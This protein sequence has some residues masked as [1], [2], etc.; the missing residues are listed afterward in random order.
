MD[1]V[2]WRADWDILCCCALLFTPLKGLVKERMQAIIK[3]IAFRL[4]LFASCMGGSCSRVLR[5]ILLEFATGRRLPGLYLDRSV[6]ITGIEKLI[7]GK[8]V[9]LHRWSYLSADGGLV[10]GD[11]VAIG[12]GTT[13]LTTEH[14]FKNKWIPMKFQ[15]I[16]NLPVNI[17]SNV[18]IG[19]NV[20]V[21]AGVT[22]GSRSVVGAGAVVTKSFPEG[23]VILAGVPARVIKTF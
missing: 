20:T 22:I 12:H 23:C 9:S 17:G 18:W 21:L 1:V 5:R 6:V 2:F 13:I 19:C 11:D 15:P 8:N 4:Y 7:L 3:K 10:I 14:T 16:E